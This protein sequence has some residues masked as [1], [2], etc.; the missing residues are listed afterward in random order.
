[1]NATEAQQ[2]SCAQPL[3]RK[4]EPGWCAVILQA[5]GYLLLVTIAI[6]GLLLAAG[7]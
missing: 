7:W 3:N 6:V 5:L 4:S 1:M 2:H